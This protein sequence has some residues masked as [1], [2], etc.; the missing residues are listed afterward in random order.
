M[1]MRARVWL[2]EAGTVPLFPGAEPVLTGFRYFWMKRVR[3]FNPREHCAGCLVGEYERRWGPKMKAGEWVD[4]EWAEGAIVY[5]CGVASPYIWKHNFHLVVKIGG[6]GTVEAPLWNAGRVEVQGAERI[7][8]D[9]RAAKELFP[10]LG[11][12][13]LSCRNFQFAAQYFG[14][15][16]AKAEP[17]EVFLDS[18]V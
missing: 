14:V 7:T 4:I 17:P 16:V 12:K 15:P 13:F 10:N 2:P 8:F 11:V 18:K 5:L 6:T 3:G 1:G 9:D